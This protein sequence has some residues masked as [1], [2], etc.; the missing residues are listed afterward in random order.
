M[1]LVQ[2]DI[3]AGELPPPGAKPIALLAEGE[4]AIEH[5]TIDAIVAEPLSADSAYRSEE[6]EQQLGEARFKS[7]IHYKGQRGKPLSAHK[8]R[9]N[10]LR[11]TIRA[12]VEHV[13]GFQQ[14][15]MGGKLIRTIG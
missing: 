15:S 2:G 13:F 5:D 8:K 10:R 9:L 4:V 3:R 6:T 7:Q 14:N 1:S 12:R 11:S